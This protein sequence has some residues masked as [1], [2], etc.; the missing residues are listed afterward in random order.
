MNVDSRFL[1]GEKAVL[2]EAEDR[3]AHL[4]KMAESASPTKGQLTGNLFFRECA[5]LPGEARNGRR[6]LAAAVRLRVGGG[7]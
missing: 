6:G 1:P 2:M 5:G 3:R 4:G 7:S